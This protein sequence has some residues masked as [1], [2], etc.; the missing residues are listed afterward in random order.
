MLEDRDYA[1]FDRTG[2]G[3]ENQSYKAP[4]KDCYASFMERV[5]ASLIDVGI[6]IIIILV[7]VLPL[8]KFL[9]SQQHDT[10]R[11]MLLFR[12][13]FGVLVVLYEAIMESSSLQGTV[14]KIVLGIRVTD[15]EMQRITFLHALGRNIAS[16]LL[17]LIPL[18]GLINTPAVLF[19]PH[20]QTLHD[21]LVQTLV[22]NDRP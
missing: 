8:W 13:V 1:Y 17:N 10:E 22:L 5:F 4:R 7:V 11:T 20:K 3:E 2:S 12:I 14:G 21:M 6:Y 9:V 18:V 16:V 15:M 19:T